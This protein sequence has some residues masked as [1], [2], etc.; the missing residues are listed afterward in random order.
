MHHVKQGVL[1]I[2]NLQEIQSTPLQ[3]PCHSHPRTWHFKPEKSPVNFAW[4]QRWITPIT[5]QM[6]LSGKLATG[7]SSYT[8]KP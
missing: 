2:W 1:A 7:F 8:W 6:E 3:H 5:R 4:L